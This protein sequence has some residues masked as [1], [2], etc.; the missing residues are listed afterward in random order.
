MQQISGDDFRRRFRPGLTPAQI[1]G[2]LGLSPTTYLNPGPSPSR[3]LP[4][5]AGGQ[6]GRN[7]I[8]AAEASDPSNLLLRNLVPPMRRSLAAQQG[9]RNSAIQPNPASGQPRVASAPPVRSNC[10]A[11]QPPRRSLF[12]IAGRFHDFQAGP[13]IAR[14]NWAEELIPVVGPA[15]DAAADLQD[16]NYGAAALNGAM[17]IGDL[18]PVGYGIKAYRGASKIAKVTGTWFPKA[19]ALRPAMKK[20]GLITNA[21]EVHHIAR[22]RGFSRNL[23]NWKNL[24]FLTKNLPIQTHQRLHRSWDGLPKFGLLPRLWY[25][26]TDWMKAGAAGIGNHLTYEAQN[27]EQWYSGDPK[28]AR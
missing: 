17:A 7:I 3:P 23:P 13:K 21:E 24:P 26:T 20:L 28:P 6:L 12:D 25:G 9:L 1:G 11:F 15:R 4:D 5:P 14:P 16:G 18:L 27:L 22:L 19:R 2:L 10:R 8:L